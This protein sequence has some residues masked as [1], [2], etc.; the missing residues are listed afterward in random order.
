[1]SH[2]AMIRYVSSSSSRS[3]IK[4]KFVPKLR[5]LSEDKDDEK[6]QRTLSSLMRTLSEVEMERWIDLLDFV[7][8]DDLRYLFFLA[9]RLSGVGNALCYG[10]ESGKECC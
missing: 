3:V 8:L 10:L 9:Y 5:A 7:P 6:K 1:M 2:H 4:T